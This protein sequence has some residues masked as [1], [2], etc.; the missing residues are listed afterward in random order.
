MENRSCASAAGHQR[1]P[2][3]LQLLRLQRN[4]QGESRAAAAAVGRRVVEPS[5]H[6]IIVTSTGISIAWTLHSPSC[7]L[8]AKSGCALIMPIEFS[9]VLQPFTKERGLYY[10]LQQPKRRIPKANA[11]TLEIT[12]PHQP[13]NGNIEIIQPETPV[14]APSKIAVDEVLINGRRYRVPEK[15]VTLD[16]WNKISRNRGLTEE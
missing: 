5:S 16:F 4:V 2:R 12:R 9:Y 13:N 11:A 15:I 6:A 1:F 8:G 3:V 14:A 10:L 7:R